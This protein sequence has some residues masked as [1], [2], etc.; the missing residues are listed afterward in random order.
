MLS[1]RGITYSLGEDPF[2]TVR[3]WYI[4]YQYDDGD[5]LGTR[6]VITPTSKIADQKWMDA[7]ILECSLPDVFESFEKWMVALNF[8][9]K[10]E[11]GFTEDDLL[12]GYNWRDEY[13]SEVEPRDAFEEWKIHTENGTRDPGN[14]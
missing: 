11:F 3:P 10:T 4:Q 5:S 7:P 9:M 6:K 12:E 13:D 14:F 8:L 2:N 1:E